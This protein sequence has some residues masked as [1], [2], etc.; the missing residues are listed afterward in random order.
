MTFEQHDAVELRRLFAISQHV[1]GAVEEAMKTRRSLVRTMDVM[2]PEIAALVGVRSVFLRTFSEDLNLTT[3][4]SDKQPLPAIAEAFLL[5]NEA[6]PDHET[7]ARA[8]GTLLVARGLDVAGE[9]FGSLGFLLDDAAEKPTDEFLASA[10][11]VIAEEIDNYLQTIRA[12]RE[13][14]RVMMA[15][16]AALRD[17]VL[18][19]GL[20][21][22]VRTLSAAVPLERLLLAVLAEDSPDAPVHLQIYEGGELTLDTLTGHGQTTDQ[23]ALLKDARAY[24]LENDPS[25]MKRLG[26]EG[27]REEVMISGIKDSVLVG[28]V[29][30]APRAGDFDTNDRELFSG[31]ADFIRQR[32]VDFG[33][34]FRTLARSF[35]TDDVTRML[36]EPD[37]REK[38]LRP[39]EERVAILFVDIS[40]FTRA[41]EKVLEGP[42][43]IGKLVDLWGDAA[44]AIVWKHRGV[45]DKM[46]GDC[47]IGLFGPP[48][49]DEGSGE[50][51]NRALCAAEEIRA[52]T[53][54]LPNR[55]GL[56]A[57]RDGGLGVSTGV[58]LAQLFVGSFGPNDNFTG[59]SSG[60]NNTARLQAQAARDEI[61]VME[62][63]ILALPKDS[64]HRFGELRHA[65][66][67]NVAEPL[68]F[69]ALKR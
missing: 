17:P 14:H 26:F 32:V 69:R 38:Y 53:A 57:L 41:C 5:A 16:A 67:K 35:R 44:V 61:L 43:Q 37:Y 33:R 46:V 8:G 60:M 39:R 4:T 36:A 18:A 34:E 63:A 47:V 42:R 9:W 27:A 54:T 3:F 1:D 2:L 19:D 40:G 64:P 12:A 29:A 23:A 62:E 28:K 10:L 15:L 30:C 59:F 66:V 52:M 24:L 20:T 21:A 6:D 22:A 7:I 11:T 45:F 65:A 55:E 31:F 56:E 58:N 50:R 51:V 48:F 49:Y 13:K 25:L 68:A